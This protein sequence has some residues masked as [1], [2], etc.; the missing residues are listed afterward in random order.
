MAD[1]NIWRELSIRFTEAHELAVP[2]WA[3]WIPGT[4]DNPSI[5][6][7]RGSQHVQTIF[8]ELA[9]LASALL[10]PNAQ[11][12]VAA[13]LTRLKDEHP[14]VSKLHP[15]ELLPDGRTVIRPGGRIDDVC[16][17][18]ADYCTDLSRMLRKTGKIGPLEKA[19]WLRKHETIMAEAQA[20]IRRNSEVMAKSN[21]LPD[22]ISDV[23]DVP[24]SGDKTQPSTNPPPA[25]V[26]EKLR[27]ATLLAEYKAATGQP[28]KQ[29]IYTAKNS[30]I[31]KPEFMK[32][33]RGELPPT[34]ATCQNFERFLK[35]KKAPIPRKPKS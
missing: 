12:K 21:V 4:T 16:R 29:K 26:D 33:Q 27:R 5:W 2:M 17:V 3:E 28:S 30:C 25:Q 31:H 15:P 18:S 34:S 19:D 20:A 1:S 11:D 13:W 8:T 32:W 14:L 7:L 6:G 24:A 10:A 22:S 9:K 35:A 23:A